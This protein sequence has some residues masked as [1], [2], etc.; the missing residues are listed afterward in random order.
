MSLLFLW[1]RYKTLF[2]SSKKLIFAALFV[3]LSGIMCGIIIGQNSFLLDYFLDYCDSYLYNVFCI[4][5]SL[6][7][8]FFNRLIRSAFTLVL[9]TACCI[10]LYFLPI[11]AVYLFIMSFSFGS[12]LT[13]LLSVYGIQGFFILLLLVLPQLLLSQG[14]T[15]LFLPVCAECCRIRL[16]CRKQGFFAVPVLLLCYF[17]LC[18]LIEMLTVLLF[19][20][21]FAFA[22]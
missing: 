10:S 8:V 11:V 7:F 2:H 15:A 9:L 19:F 6:F 16:I 1:N 18:A 21:P 14:L 22:L 20:R 12:L 5:V 4:D 13:V 3:C 17:I